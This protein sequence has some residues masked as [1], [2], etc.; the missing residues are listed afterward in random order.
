[1]TFDELIQLAR[2]QSSE[3]QRDKGTLFEKIA[4]IYFKNEPTYKNLFSDVWLL[5]EVPEE[6]AIPKK[7][8][9]VDLV[10]RNEATGELT[11]IQAKFYDNKIYKRHIDSFLA[12]L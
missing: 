9:G 5:N 2:E 8:T 6:Y 4:Q 3:I 12:E 1:M 11:A 10:A 7:D